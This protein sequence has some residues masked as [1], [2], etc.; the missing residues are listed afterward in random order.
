[1]LYLDPR[2]VFNTGA[3]GLALQKN[4]SSLAGEEIEFHSGVSFQE[5]C[6]GAESVGV[7]C[8]TDVGHKHPQTAMGDVVEG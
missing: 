2:Y 6:L 5:E 4:P 3:L 8:F 7:R 1:M